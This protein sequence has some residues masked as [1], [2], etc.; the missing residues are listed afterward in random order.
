MVRLTWLP[1]CGC[2]LCTE[3]LVL[4]I[5]GESER[6]IARVFLYVGVAVV[7]VLGVIVLVVVD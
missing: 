6:A 7:V 3:A 1:E 2:G 4:I 5:V